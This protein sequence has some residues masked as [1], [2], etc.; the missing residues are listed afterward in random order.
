MPGPE[1]HCAPQTRNLE[2]EKTFAAWGSEFIRQFRNMWQV[3]SLECGHRI[4]NEQ[5]ASLVLSKLFTHYIECRLKLERPA[6]RVM[7]VAGHNVYQSTSHPPQGIFLR[8]RAKNSGDRSSS[9][10]YETS[11]PDPFR[12]AL[13][14][15]AQNG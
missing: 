8:S 10:L 6:T 5:G 9:H 11:M 4:L 14:L 7:C 1:C 3:A 15:Q 2:K 13:R 12:K